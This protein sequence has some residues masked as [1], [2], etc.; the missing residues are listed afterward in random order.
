MAIT[1]CLANS[2]D[3][4]KLTNEVVDFDDDIHT[5][6]YEHRG[7]FPPQYHFLIEF[8]PY[9]D[10]IL[11]AKDIESLVETCNY[12]KM[13][14]GKENEIHFAERLKNLCLKALESNKSIVALGD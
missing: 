7:D 1:F 3:E 13:N 4:A 6:L 5:V 8:D 14:F 10:E 12:L 11:N 9:G 2:V